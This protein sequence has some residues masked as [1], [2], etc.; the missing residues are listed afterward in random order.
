[1][2][3]AVKKASITKNVKGRCFQQRYPNTTIFKNA[4]FSS[5]MLCTLHV[6]LGRYEFTLDCGYSD[7]KESTEP[8]SDMRLKERSVFS[9]QK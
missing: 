6:L 1:M 8:L 4:E 5:Q 2:C 9:L 7:D 3:I